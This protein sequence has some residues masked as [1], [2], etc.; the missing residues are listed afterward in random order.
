MVGWFWSNYLPN[1]RSA[2]NEPAQFSFYGWTSLIQEL[3]DKNNTV[4]AGV[5]ASV[6]G[7][8]A[9]EEK[10]PTIRRKSHE[11][12]GWTLLSLA[13][14][15]QEPS[16]HPSYLILAALKLLGYYELWS[17]SD[18]G[19]HP[20][21]FKTWSSHVIVGI[22]LRKPSPLAQKEWKTIPWKIIPKTAL[23][24]LL[25][26]MIDIP[27]IYAE[28]DSINSSKDQESQQDRRKQLI[29]RCWSLSTDLQSWEAVSGRAALEFAES[30]LE[31]GNQAPSNPLSTEDLSKGIFALLYWATCI[32]IY[33][34]LKTETDLCPSSPEAPKIGPKVAEPS[35]YC[36]QV[37]ALLPY[38]LDPDKKTNYL[39]LYP[40]G[41][42][43][44]YQL[45]VDQGRPSETQ[46]AL[47]QA[48]TGHV[49]KVALGFMN[50][51]HGF[52]PRTHSSSE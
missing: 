34:V 30:V 48:F 39:L 47:M 6:L 23:D 17:T 51:A 38:L 32:M 52:G 15:L 41:I 4:R 7:R 18:E 49:G 24:N 29:A 21:P 25:D 31:P 14:I 11:L 19:G 10:S 26:I 3:Y 35:L 13:K 8:M 36:R 1:G 45:K 33:D 5:M 42:A 9:E 43:L 20:N 22:K 46:T 50:D 37:A 40:A 28:V 44:Q 16:K 2:S 12:Y 27:G